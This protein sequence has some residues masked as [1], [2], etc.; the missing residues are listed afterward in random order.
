MAGQ[1]EVIRGMCAAYTTLL[2][3]NHSHRGVVTPLNFTTFFTAVEERELAAAAKIPGHAGLPAGRMQSA[4]RLSM[5]IAVNTKLHALDQPIDATTFDDSAALSTQLKL[6][7]TVE[8]DQEEQA[9]DAEPT[10]RPIVAA[11]FG[12][13]ESPLTLGQQ[14]VAAA[15]LYDAVVAGLDCSACVVLPFKLVRLGEI[16]AKA[17]LPADQALRANVGNGGAG[18]YDSLVDADLYDA[19]GKSLPQ[20]EATALALFGNSKRPADFADDGSTA[21]RSRGDHA[22]VLLRT[23]RPRETTTTKRFIRPKLD[24]N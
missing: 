7:S 24:L 20:L 3:A 6:L 1:N 19:L 18:A 9:H 14:L 13:A 12:G 23:L 10:A 2:E 11:I 22:P 15:A 16:I 8:A 5:A 4:H 17:D 21:K